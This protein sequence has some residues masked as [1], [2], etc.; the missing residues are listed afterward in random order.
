MNLYKDLNLFFFFMCRRLGVI[1]LGTQP[2]PKPPNNQ[3]DTHGSEFAANYETNFGAEYEN[4][5]GAAMHMNNTFA[6]DD[7]FT[8]ICH[9][10]DEV[11]QGREHELIPEEDESGAE[12]NPSG[13]I[14]GNSWQDNGMDSSA[15]SYKSADDDFE[16]CDLVV[17]EYED[18]VP[19]SESS[20]G[21]HVDIGTNC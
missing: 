1:R 8:Q 14:P 11:K 5:K 18:G 16:D 13:Q 12:Q 21:D 9:F 20:C 7:T 15:F 19:S 3:V 4:V 2:N 17:A 10:Y 6:D